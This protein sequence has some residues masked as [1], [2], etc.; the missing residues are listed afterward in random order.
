MVTKILLG[1]IVSVFS[2]MLTR[3]FLLLVGHLIVYRRPRESKHIR[4]L[5]DLMSHLENGEEAVPY[6]FTLAVQRAIE[7]EGGRL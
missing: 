3:E 5:K 4:D 1:I 7:K 6:R 2:F